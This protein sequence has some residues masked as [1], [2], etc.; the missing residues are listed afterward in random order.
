M[1]D[2]HLT[3][4]D[5]IADYIREFWAQIE[6]RPRLPL[7]RVGAASTPC[8]SIPISPRMSSGSVLPRLRPR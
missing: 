1:I 8:L 2:T 6:V 3:P 7:S 4:S 5:P